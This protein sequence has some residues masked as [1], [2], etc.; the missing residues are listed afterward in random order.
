MMWFADNGH[1]TKFQ[2]TP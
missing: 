1:T 2:I